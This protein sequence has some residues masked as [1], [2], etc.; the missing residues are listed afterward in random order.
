MVEMV[1]MLFV[2]ALFFEALAIVLDMWGLRFFSMLS[3]FALAYLQFL[4]YGTVWSVFVMFIFAGLALFDI[5][6]IM[7]NIFTWREERW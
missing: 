1:I 5:V 2:L 7:K 4:H 3:W 6:V